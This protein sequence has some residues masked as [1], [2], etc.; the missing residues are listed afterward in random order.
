M[1]KEGLLMIVTIGTEEEEKKNGQ[2]ILIGTWK[3][4]YH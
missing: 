2:E 3:S 4:R 1:K